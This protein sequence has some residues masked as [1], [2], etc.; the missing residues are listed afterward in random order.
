MNSCVP[1]ASARRAACLLAGWRETEPSVFSATS[2]EAERIELVNR[3]AE[4]MRDLEDPA[5]LAVCVRLLEHLRGPI[6]SD[7]ASLRLQ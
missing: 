7:L 5:D 4:Q 2:G 1:T 3:I 6:W